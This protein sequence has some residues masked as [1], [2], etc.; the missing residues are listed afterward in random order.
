M[1]VDASL[2]TGGVNPIRRSRRVARGL[3]SASLRRRRSNRFT[4]GDSPYSYQ[5]MTARRAARQVNQAETVTSLKKPERSVHAIQSDVPSTPSA[6]F[7][8]AYVP[9]SRRSFGCTAVAHI[10]A[11]AGRARR[12]CH[13]GL[14]CR[15]PGRHRTGRPLRSA[16]DRRSRSCLDTARRRLRC[17]RG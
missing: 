12:K 5:D 7:G 9:E 2:R 3:L 15:S 4:A 16:A 1:Q 6:S 11:H 17:H 8:A 14:S 13:R 10:T